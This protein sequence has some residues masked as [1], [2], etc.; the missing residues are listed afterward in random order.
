MSKVSTLS[1]SRPPSSSL[2]VAAPAP[3]SAGTA[4]P[5][6]AVNRPA[7]PRTSSQRAQS[8]SRRPKSASK[9][10]GGSDKAEVAVTNDHR[11]S[12]PAVFVESDNLTAQRKYVADE[13]KKWLKQQ[14]QKGI[15]G[16]VVFD[17]DDTLINGNEAVAHGFEHMVDPFKWASVHF[18]V[19]FVTA[20]PEDDKAH[21]MGLLHSDKRRLCIHWN[22]LHMMKTEEYHSGE[23]KFV[24]D[25][26]WGKHKEFVKKYGV[27]L[28][29]LGDRLWDV[30]ERRSPDTY[31][32]H[33][34]DEACYI[35]SDPVLKGTRSFKLPEGG[36]R[37]S[38]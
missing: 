23:S 4:R 14:L 31:L 5:A 20:R 7:S 33:V 26:K 11:A 8:P 13:A 37:R 10:G 1:A 32:R 16:A 6:K 22:H 9:S 27:V 12:F 24:K 19:E 34:G 36:R 38:K 2:S 15:R 18:P 17:I 29:R 25:F 21:V 28:A 30:A 3:L 35:F